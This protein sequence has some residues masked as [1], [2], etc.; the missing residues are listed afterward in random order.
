MP[1][2]GLQTLQAMQN[3]GIKNA[4]LETDSVLL[5]DK[6]EVLKQAKKL[7]IGLCGVKT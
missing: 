4:A 5:L 2:F 6:V 7:G 3:A 1:V